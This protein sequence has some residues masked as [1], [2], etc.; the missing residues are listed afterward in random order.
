MRRIATMVVLCSL[1]A[2][3]GIQPSGPEDAGRAPTG[4][5]RGTTLYFVDDQ[6]VVRP[7][8]RPTGRLGTIA[9]ALAL[10]LTGAGDSSLHSEIAPS[11]VTQVVTTVTARTIRLRVPL[12]VREV[13]PRG[14][15]QIVCT[16][17]GVHV[18]GG[19][20]R[21]TRVQVQFTLPTPASAKRRTCP[22][23]G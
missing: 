8:L 6:G 7:D 1:L 14:I 5:A 20:S 2:G 22:V 9:D 3:C 15:D 16:A 12:S 23:L 19:G 4:V 21:R 13:T 10:L 18:Q 17:L 11:S